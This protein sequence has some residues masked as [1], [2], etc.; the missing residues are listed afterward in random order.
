MRSVDR[1]AV[2]IGDYACQV[3]G[4]ECGF[5]NQETMIEAQILWFENWSDLLITGYSK[6]EYLVFPRIQ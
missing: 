1:C 6:M 2:A 4:A 5:D 3:S